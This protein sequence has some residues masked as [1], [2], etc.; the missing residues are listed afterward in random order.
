LYSLVQRDITVLAIRIGYGTAG[1]E[2]LPSPR[3]LQAL[4]QAFLGAALATVEEFGG[5]PVRSAIGC[6]RHCCGAL[7]GWPAWPA[8]GPD[9]R[10]LPP[11]S[12]RGAVV[13]VPPE[14]GAP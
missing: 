11:A 8:V 9:S 5:I 1:G 3:A 2:G 12:T 4:D 13:C 7:W 14:P 6:A 10:R